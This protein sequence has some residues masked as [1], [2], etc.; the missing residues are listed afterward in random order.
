MSRFQTGRASL[1]LAAG[2]LAALAHPPFDIWP[3]FF[4]YALLLAVVDS[5]QGPGRLWRAF[6]AGWLAGFGYFLVGC[7]WVVEA[8]LVDAE[9][10]AWMAPFAVAALPAGLGLFWGAACLLYRWIAP[11]GV[12]RVFVFAAIFS[13]FEWL[14]GHVLTGFPWNLPGETWAAGSAP[15]QGAAWLGA[16]GMTFVTVLGMAA[17]AP[18]LTAG[19]RKYRSGIA[20]VGAV[21]IAA[22]WIVGSTR[23]SGAVVR[24]SGVN[25]RIVQPQVE[26]ESKWSQDRFNDIVRRYANLTS[27]T[28]EIDPD[29]VV[30]PEGALPTS[31]DVELDPSKGVAT[32]IARSL[33]PNQILLLGTYRSVEKPGKPAQYFNSLYAVRRDGD[34]LKPLATY[35]KHR[36]VPFG[37]YMPLDSWMQAMGVKSWTHVGDGF[38]AGPRP[39]PMTVKGMPRV[40]PLICYESLFP[41][42]AQDGTG[43]AAWIVNVSNDSWFGRATGPLSHFLSG[44][45]QHL[46]QA[47]YRAIEQGLPL[48]RATPTGV[49]A[50]V[51]PWGRVLK[52]KRLNPGESGVIDFMLPAPA[53][54]TFYSQMGD[55]LFWILVALGMVFAAPLSRLSRK[56]P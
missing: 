34:L 43:R 9:H 15:S 51:D 10:Q 48:V 26:Q 21:V 32:A 35:D 14:R 22:L 45:L 23:L 1:S 53:A 52:G 2:V 36:L 37:E 50:A 30:W 5:D 24:P 33:T 41:G 44:P 12:R 29:I 55:L 3:G 13:V 11:S 4:G 54:P 40:Q 38:T 42:L 31:V 8:F 49:S 25:V 56:T 7:W 28:G 6:G 18:L 27:R 47:S 17:F 19:N 46:N 20:V 39:E 16:Y